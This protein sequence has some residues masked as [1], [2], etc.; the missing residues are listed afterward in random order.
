MGDLGLTLVEKSPWRSGMAAHSSI[1]SEKSMDCME[2]WRI[3]WSRK[4]MNMTEQLP[5]SFFLA[6]ESIHSQA[7]SEEVYK[8]VFQKPIEL[9]I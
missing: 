5:L 8:S 6:E 4:R 1:L 2:S 9:Y 3:P 7:C